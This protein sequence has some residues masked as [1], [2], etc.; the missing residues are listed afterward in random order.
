MASFVRESKFRHCHVALAP[1]EEH[2]EQL[3]VANTASD[4]NNV[5]CNSQF[6]AYI[7][8]AAGG[9][10]VAVLPLSSVGKNHIPVLAPTYQ[11]PLIRAHSSPVQDLAFS[12]LNTQKNRIYTCSSDATLKLW[13][14]PVNGF[15]VDSVSALSVHSSANSVP[16]RGI[17]CHTSVENIVAARGTRDVFVFDTSVEASR[18]IFSIGA[19]VFGANDLQS[20]AWS[21]D[22][23]LLLTT[24]KDK[25]LRQFDI[26]SST[27]PV[28]TLCPHGGN[29]NSRAI[30][31]GNS[32]YFLSCGHTATQDR[33]FTVWDSRNTETVVKRERIDS[34]TGMIIPLF[35]TD[36]NLL[37]LSGKGDTSARLYEFDP[38]SGAI[39]AVS[40]TPLGDVIK[41]AS[42]LPKQANNLMACEVLRMLK[43]T[44]NSIQPVSYT[45]PRKE[46][47]KFHDDL[48]P[49]TFWEIPPS[50]TT[51]DWKGGATVIPTPQPLEIPKVAT[52]STGGSVSSPVNAT[53]P[54]TALSEKSS[55]GPESPVVSGSRPSS[56]AF[57][58]E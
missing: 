32:P 35:D 39:F 17:A 29:R 3:R 40:N 7:D 42:M 6:L 41:G 25:T 45:V 28:T 15:I 44:D 8:N 2:Y 53:E 1:R 38:S 21:F 50:A 14:I 57:G 5:S 27:T 11:Q 19:D 55:S 37:I 51:E 48:Y 46:K 52:V 18:P 9:A 34:S 23:A 10:A 47:L 36:T 24:G 56:M 54:V 31:L 16:F 58:G 4:G 30:W 20:F 49:P 12:G 33:E 26:R 13:D 22:G 43:L